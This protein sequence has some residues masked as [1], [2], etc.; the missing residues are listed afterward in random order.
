MAKS[1]RECR[2]FGL[3]GAGPV[4]IFLSYLLVQKGHKVTLYEAGNIESET[5]NLSL[6]HYIFKTKSKIP[7]GVHRVGGASNLWKRR[8]SEFSSEVFNRR[9][10]NGKRI[11]PID[12]QELEVANEKLFKYLDASGLRDHEFLDSYLSKVGGELAHLV[13]LNLY[14]F[15]DENFFTNLLEELESNDDFRIFT[16]TLVTEICLPKESEFD[17][18]RIELL[19]LTEDSENVRSVFHSDV[20][21]TGGCL[22]STA[23]A[24]KSKDIIHAH[25]APEI[26]GKFLMEHFDGYIG[27]VRIKKENQQLLKRLVLDEDR[28]IPGKNF[29][30]GISNP[31]DSYLKGNGIAY[32][33]ELVKWRKTYL[34]DPNLNVF[35]RLPKR[36]YQICFFLERIL[37]KL[38]SE[39]REVIFRLSSTEIYS[40]WLKGEEFPFS[41]SQLMISSDSDP[42]EVKLVYNHRVSKESRILMRRRLLEFSAYLKE[43]N[44]GRL[45]IHSYF[46]FNSLFYT[47]PNF[48]PM[49]SLR[50]GS[51]PKESVVGPD[52]AFHNSPHVYAVN[53]GIFPSGSNHNPTAMVLALSL[54]F[55]SKF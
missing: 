29:G 32:H 15:C 47:G 36:I 55:A 17:K 37:K 16:G 12:F 22:Q 30:L 49:G 24:L 33:L 25:P 3:I 23:L 28:K 38:P 1:E 52:F 18:N 4:G 40:V 45:R 26:I 31:S 5:R 8:V 35:N 7:S 10:N 48:H 2:N 43:N 11:W 21:L 14:R 53:S 41:G 42:R 50:M 44:L 51:D 54:V 9:D 27:T 13:S 46:Y 20:V 6:S 19:F 34:F 39:M